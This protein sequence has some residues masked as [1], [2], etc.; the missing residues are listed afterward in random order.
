[1]GEG[2]NE[3]LVYSSPWEFNSY[4]LQHLTAWDLPALLPIR[5]EGVLR[6]FIALKNPST[7]PGSNPQTSGP[8]ARTLTTTPP[9]RLILTELR[10]QN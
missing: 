2:V 10:H 9:R 5:E 6:I 1:M 3:N 7:W 8:V 4:M